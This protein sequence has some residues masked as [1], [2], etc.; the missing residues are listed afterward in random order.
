MFTVHNVMC[1]S[2]V[3][4]LLAFVCYYEQ[5]WTFDSDWSVNVFITPV[6][7]ED[8]GNKQILQIDEQKN[9]TK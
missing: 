9:A 3:M 4:I 7:T 1:S 6:P 5:Y 8:A 2:C